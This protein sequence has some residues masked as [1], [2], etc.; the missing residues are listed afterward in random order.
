VEGIEH[1][2]NS[3]QAVETDAFEACLTN[4]FGGLDRG[5][6]RGGGGCDGVESAKGAGGVERHGCG[7]GQCEP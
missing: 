1:I 3:R 6:G 4:V 2:Y 7:R 5:G